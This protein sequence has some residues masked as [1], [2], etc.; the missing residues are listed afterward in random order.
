MRSRCF[1]LT[2]DGGE[3][4]ALRE[5]IAGDAVAHFDAEVDGDLGLALHGLARRRVDGRHGEKLRSPDQPPVVLREILGDVVPLSP[6]ARVLTVAEAGIGFGFLALV[7]GYLPILYQSFSRREMNVSLLDARAGSPPTAGS[8]LVRH[9]EGS[10]PTEALTTFL[11]DWEI[12]SADI[13]ESHLSYPT[14]AFFRSQ[15]DN[16]SWVS[17]LTV[18]LDAC[19]LVLVG[20]DGFVDF[21]ID[22]VDKRTGPETYTRVDTIASLGERISRAA[23]LSSNLELVVRHPPSSE[24]RNHLLEQQRHAPVL[25]D[26]RG[27]HL[28]HHLRRVPVER[29]D[30]VLR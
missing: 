24:R 27:E 20:L 12:W 30:E 17:S 3:R 16:Q 9:S 28:L 26:A 18:I 22:V 25:S 10:N 1:G 14:L 15:H 5:S 6:L 7:I 13:L 8:L 23:G 21:I 19:A 11:H 29:R 2:V 4:G